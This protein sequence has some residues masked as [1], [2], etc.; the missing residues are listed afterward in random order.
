MEVYRNENPNGFIEIKNT[1]LVTNRHVII[2]RYKNVEVIPDSFTFNLRK[3]VNNDILKWDPITIYREELLDRLKVHRDKHVDIG[4]VRVSDL[5]NSR[6]ASNKELKYVDPFG[7]SKLNMVG[8]NNINVEVTDDVIIIGYPKGYYDEFNLYPIVKSGIVSSGW[9]LYFDGQPYFLIDAKLFPGSSGSIV[10]SKPTNTTV[11][12]G[13]MMY[14]RDKQFAF[15]GIYSSDRQDPNGMY[16]Y[17][18]G[19]VWY[20]HLIED[21]IRNGESWN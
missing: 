5:V 4:I 18:I 20:A 16:D 8:N 13:K 6:I 15:L 10:F 1:W 14:S 17:N 12:N 9:G 2:H 21:I 7:V 3:I 19:K 11:V